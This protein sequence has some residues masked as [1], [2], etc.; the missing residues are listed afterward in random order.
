MAHTSYSVAALLEKISSPDKDFRFMAANDL[1]A[2][3]SKQTLM[4]DEDTEYKVKF[5]SLKEIVKVNF[6]LI[7]FK[8]KKFLHNTCEIKNFP[9]TSSFPF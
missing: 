3:L 4:L 1:L 8:K 9:Y 6:F 2:E 7:L 5:L